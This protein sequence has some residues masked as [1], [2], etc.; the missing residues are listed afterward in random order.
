MSDALAPLRSAPFRWLVLASTINRVGGSI[1]PIALAF[2]VLDLTG[3]A[4]SL[5]LVVGARSLANVIFLLIGGVV[6]DRLPRTVVLVGSSV[7]SAVTQAVVALLIFQRVDSVALLAALSALNG[8]SSA[9]A[10]PASAALI[11]QTVAPSERTRANALSRLG[12]NASGVLGTSMAGLIVAVWGSAW[13]I[14]ID[15]ASF[16]IAA[17]FFALVRIGTAPRRS[18]SSSVLRDLAAG[19]SEFVSRTWLWVVVAAFG[20]INA[21]EVGGVA[22]LGPVVADDTI[23]RRAWGVVIAAQAVGYV[24]GGLFAVRLRMRRLLLFGMV[25]MLPEGLILLALAAHASLPVLLAASFVGGLGLEQ[26]G[27]AWQTSM[28]QHV[29]GDVLARVSS[30]DALGSFIAIP[31]GEV[32]AGPASH[33]IGTRGALLAATALVLLATLATLASRSVRTLANEDEMVQATAY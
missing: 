16:A 15:A 31:L 10:L 17:G 2:A 23:G 27:V 21:A 18:V 32:A 1:A 3:S 29:P 5:G 6:A 26:F 28:H 20:V 25:C 24:V 11:P 9:F 22:V 30:Y 33:A 8:T 12:I 4:T 19:W 13:G 14:A 7:A